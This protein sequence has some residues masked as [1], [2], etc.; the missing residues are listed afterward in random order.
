MSI[1]AKILSKLGYT[2]GINKDEAAYVTVS[3]YPNTAT[4]IKAIPFRQYLTLTGESGG[5]SNMRVSASLS[6]PSNFFIS[7]QVKHDIYIKT[8]SVSIV[9]AGSTLDKFGNITA[10]S[11]GIEFFW[12]NQEQGDV[13]IHE[14][15]KSNW[16]FIRL[17]QGNPAFGD[18]ANSFRAPNV[19][20]TS[21]GYMP[22]IDFTKIFGLPWGIKL[23][24]GTTDRIVF[25]I[26]DNV[27]GLDSFD[28]IGYGT[29]IIE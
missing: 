22:V 13:V 8:I 7:A 5:T 10:L 11:N 28:A 18:A 29:K 20:S 27:T 9:D 15:L 2:L 25:R 26:K 6:S 17:S 14:S 1:S 24:K 23:K 21:E 19:V 4:K 16:D 12:F 3:D